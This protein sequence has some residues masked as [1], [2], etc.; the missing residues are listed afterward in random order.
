MDSQ[1]VDDGKVDGEVRGI[2]RSIVRPAESAAAVGARAQSDRHFRVATLLLERGY[3]RE[4]VFEAQKAMRL[5][6]PRP[7]QQATY[8]WALYRRSGAGQR[9]PPAVWQHLENA[10]EADPNCELARYYHAELMK[11]EGSC[12]RSP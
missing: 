8:A 7:E 9:V 10:L 3:P 2:W 1:P 4:A 6:P 12:S 11:I 5:C